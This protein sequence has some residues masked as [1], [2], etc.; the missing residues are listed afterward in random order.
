MTSWPFS[1]SY[2]IDQTYF[3]KQGGHNII[4]RLHDGLCPKIKKRGGMG[5]KNFDK[6]QLFVEKFTVHN[7]SAPYKAG[8]LDLLKENYVHVRHGLT[9]RKQGVV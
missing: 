5:L 4:R 8:I 1:I 3:T 6:L 7:L 9:E 2:Q